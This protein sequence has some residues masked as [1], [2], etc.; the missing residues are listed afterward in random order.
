MAINE[1]SVIIKE[2]PPKVTDLSVMIVFSN[3]FNIPLEQIKA[4]RVGSNLGLNIELGQGQ[5]QHWTTEYIYT[6][7]VGK[8]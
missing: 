6:D 7:F 3:R 1:S 5:Q 8:R 2:V 4:A